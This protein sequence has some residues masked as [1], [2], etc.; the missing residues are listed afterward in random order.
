VY[1]PSGTSA[2]LTSQTG[3]LG[4]QTGLYAVPDI[5]CINQYD[6]TVNKESNRRGYIL[7]KEIWLPYVRK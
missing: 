5:K 3:G 1:D 7:Q 2:T 4:G 6:E